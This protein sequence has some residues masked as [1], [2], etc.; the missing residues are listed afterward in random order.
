MSAPAIPPHPH[1]GL[2]L[3]PLTLD[4]TTRMIVMGATASRDWQP[5]H[6]DPAA[7]AAAGLPGIIMN[8][9]AQ[10]GLIS[11]Y[12]TDWTGPHGRIGRLRFAMKRPLCPG[13]SALLQGVVVDLAPGGPDLLWVEIDLEIKVAETVATTAS[14]R[15]ALPAASDAASPWQ[16]PAAAWRP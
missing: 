8:N 6:H 12:V 11:R 5:Q 3:P 14:V 13:A 4:I 2:R 16:C 10:A 1:V 9:Y 7:A 15:V